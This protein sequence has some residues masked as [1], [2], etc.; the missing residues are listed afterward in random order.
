MPV[1]DLDLNSILSSYDALRMKNRAERDQRI[2]EVYQ[3]VPD[4]YEL[5]QQIESFGIRAMQR[6]LRTKEK[7]EELMT[8]VKKEVEDLRTR[9]L[10][11]LKRAGFAED[12][13]ELRYS[14]PYCQDTGF[15]D[16]KRCRCLEQRLIALSYKRSNLESL[17]ATQNFDHFDLN[18]F[19]AEGNPSVR[20]NMTRILEVVQQAISRYDGGMGLNFLLTG[21]TGTGKTFLCSCIAKAVMDRGFTVLYI[22]AYDFNTIMSDHR[23][24]YRDQDP[25]TSASLQ[26]I[27]DCDLLILDDLGTEAPNKTTAADFLHCIDERIRFGRSTIISTNQS[28]QNLGKLYSDRLVSR[29]LGHFRTLPFSGEDLR[30]KAL[31]KQ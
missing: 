12:Y 19:S 16:G 21:S 13:M 5:D 15:T 22:S 27:Y 26:Y 20:D 2:Q 7:P 31:T 6:Y 8:S 11:L 9:K 28:L 30:L 17:L 29:L 1:S 10:F 18:I 14:C 3:A 24:R 4:I 23:Y 25:N